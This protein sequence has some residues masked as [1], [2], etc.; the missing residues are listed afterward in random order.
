[1]NGQTNPTANRIQ[2]L[3]KASDEVRYI[4]TCGGN[5][6]TTRY[7]KPRCVA[8]PASTSILVR[9]RGRGHNEITTSTNSAPQHTPGFLAPQTPDSLI[10][11]C[12]QVIVS[13]REAPSTLPPPNYR[14]TPFPSHPPPRQPTA[15]STH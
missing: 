11:I 2:I 14:P 4:H 6:R 5:L 3:L 13:T 15:H 1:M 10:I 8:R 12:R 9:M 7:Q